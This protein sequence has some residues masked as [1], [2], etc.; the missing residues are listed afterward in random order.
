ME[1]EEQA[2]IFRDSLSA[3][4]QYKLS[5]LIPYRGPF[6]VLDVM[7]YRYPARPWSDIVKNVYAF[8]ILLPNG[9]LEVKVVG[10]DTPEEALVTIS[11]ELFPEVSH[12]TQYV[13]KLTVVTDLIKDPVQ[14]KAGIYPTE[15]IPDVLV[16]IPSP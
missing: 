12:R 1:E 8:A 3:G 4:E 10:A 7:I 11:R 9:R 2:K 15:A 5:C 13:S 16:S 14:R 6:S